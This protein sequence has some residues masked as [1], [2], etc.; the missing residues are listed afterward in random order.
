L[1]IIVNGRK[2]RFIGDGGFCNKNL[3]KGLP[4]E[5]DLVTRCR[6]DAKLCFRST[7][8][9]SFYARERFTPRDVRHDKS[10]RTRSTRI[11]YY[12]AKRKVKFKDV[13]NVYWPTGGQKRPL[14]L[15]V[16][17]AQKVKAPKSG[18]YYYREPIQLLTTDLTSS[19]TDIIRSY[20]G[21]NEIEHVIET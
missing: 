9:R 7:N 15:I 21:R 18:K 14:R 17:S 19:A 16:I 11:Y 10:I 8:N 5:A 2:V 6:W 13:K 4:E 1:T 12:G 3:F 20:F